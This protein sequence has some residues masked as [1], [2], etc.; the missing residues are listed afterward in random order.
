MSSGFTEVRIG[1]RGAVAVAAVGLMLAADAVHSACLG[2]GLHQ[3]LVVCIPPA[4]PAHL[5]LAAASDH[6]PRGHVP[7]DPSR[8]IKI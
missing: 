1:Q 2:D 6:R 5:R 8:G 7:G 4:P 3:V